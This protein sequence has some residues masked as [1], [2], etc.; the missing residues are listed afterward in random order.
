[1]RTKMRAERREGPRRARGQAV[2]PA[3]PRLRGEATRGAQLVGAVLARPWSGVGQTRACRPC[4]SCVS[5][6]APSACLIVV[7]ALP[8]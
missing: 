4:N 8:L 5:R 2:R 7:A 6:V 3:G 1:M